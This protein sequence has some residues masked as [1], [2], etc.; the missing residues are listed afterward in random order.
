ME[1]RYEENRRDVTEQQA[2]RERI[3][4]I[5]DRMDDLNR[6]YCGL[7]VSDNLYIQCAGSY[8]EMIVEIRV[9]HP[10][11]FRHYAIGQILEPSGEVLE[12]FN[13][14]TTELLFH[15]FSETQDVPSEFVKRDMTDEFKRA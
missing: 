13:A 12:T 1:F 9:P 10:D 3:R 14:E 11:G 7:T 5:L 6:T 15:S 4:Q 2:S 8:E